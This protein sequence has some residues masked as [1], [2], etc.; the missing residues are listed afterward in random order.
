MAHFLITVGITI[1]MGFFEGLA[2]VCSLQ[3][4]LD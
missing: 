4:T 1:I 3:P 2:I